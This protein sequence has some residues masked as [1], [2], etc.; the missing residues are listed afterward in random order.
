MKALTAT[1][2]TAAILLLLGCQQASTEAPA[3]APPPAPAAKTEDTAWSAL[4][5]NAKQPMD[6]VVS[7]GQ[8]TAEQLEQAAAAGYRTVINLRTEG[9]PGIEDQAALVADLGMRY[10]HLPVAGAP[11]VT[12]A[13]ARELTR[14]LEESERPILLHCGSGNRV[15]A[16]LALS[17]YYVDGKSA[18]EAIDYG[19]ESG[20]TRLE[21]AVREHL[22]AAGAP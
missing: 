10:V 16:L 21:P 20:L 11:D 14:L 3:E 4:V 22:S 19:L 7:G 6:G 2:T 5:P 8:P 9:E 18:E 17:S 15:G 12:E 1:A 13:N